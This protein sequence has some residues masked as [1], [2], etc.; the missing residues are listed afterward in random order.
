MPFGGIHG[1]RLKMSR[2]RIATSFTLSIALPDRLCFGAPEFA[3]AT[4]DDGD[5]APAAIIGAA[6]ALAGAVCAA[7]VDVNAPIN[8][9]A[10]AAG[11]A[12]LEKWPSIVINAGS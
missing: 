6:T 9:I 3:A 12:V 2:A 11:I 10:S 5:A 7:T 4:V 1:T 8:M